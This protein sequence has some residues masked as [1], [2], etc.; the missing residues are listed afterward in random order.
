M[1][2][3]DEWYALHSQDCYD[4]LVFSTMYCNRCVIIRTPNVYGEHNQKFLELL[5][6][7]RLFGWMRILTVEHNKCSYLS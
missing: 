6:W 2:Y 4:N 3:D 5:R 7:L 1:T